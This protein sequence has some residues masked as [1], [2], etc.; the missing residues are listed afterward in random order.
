MATLHAASSEAIM[1]GN[2][3]TFLDAVRPGLTLYGGYVSEAAR[4]RGALRPAYRLKTRV[5]RV[6]HL[7]AGEGVSYHRRW[8]A[9]RPTWTATLAVGHVDGY[10]SGSVRGGEV[11]ARGRLFPVIGTVSAS[12]TIISIG[13]ERALDVGDEVTLVGPDSPALHPNEIAKRAGWS[14]YNMFMHLSP[15]LP[16]IVVGEAAR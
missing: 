10:P 14:E 13:A 1:H 4:E 16:R 9:D 7:S 12:H 8:T 11:F 2:A 5:I 3:D 15:D 6:D